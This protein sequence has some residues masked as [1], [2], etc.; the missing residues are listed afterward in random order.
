M[1]G[2]GGLG[3]CLLFP[4]RE[5]EV[6]VGFGHGLAQGGDG[7]A[8]V[9]QWGEGVG[10][11]AAG[12]LAGQLGFV[13]RIGEA[14]GQAHGQAAPV[15]GG[16]GAEGGAADGGEQGRAFHQAGGGEA[17]GDGG[18]PKLLRRVLVWRVLGLGG[19][20]VAH[21]ARASGAASSSASGSMGGGG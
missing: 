5:G 11:A 10:D 3:L 15:H 21:A 20:P 7:G 4:R 6:R 14:V 12:G 9:E 16:G 13:V 1:A 19:V 8:G 18:G 2:D 17:A